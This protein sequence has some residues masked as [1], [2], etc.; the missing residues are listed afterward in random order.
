MLLL[1]S[2]ARMAKQI[3][4]VSALGAAITRRICFISVRQAQ[5]GRARVEKEP[6]MGTGRHVEW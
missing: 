1:Q 4:I 6:P 3:F 5:R 2:D